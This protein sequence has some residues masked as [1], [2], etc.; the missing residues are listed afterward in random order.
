MVK[1][2]VKENQSI[3]DQPNQGIS[4]QENK[5]DFWRV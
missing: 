3:K 1:S 4:F 2:V 5:I